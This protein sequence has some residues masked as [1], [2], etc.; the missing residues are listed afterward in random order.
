MANL[1][2]RLFLRNSAVGALAST[3]AVPSL[4]QASG[5]DTAFARARYHYDQFAAAMDELTTGYHG[6]L[7]AGGHRREFSAPDCRTIE[8]ASWLGPKLVEYEAGTDPRCPSRVVE[9]NHEIIGLQKQPSGW[10]D[11][12]LYRDGKGVRL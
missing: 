2:R 9:W 8:D 5:Q 11:E 4:A 1:S 7:I 12:P 10:L 6:W 3:V